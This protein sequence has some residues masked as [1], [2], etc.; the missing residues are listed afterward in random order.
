MDKKQN[1]MKVLIVY[2]VGLADDAKS[3]FREYVKQGIDLSVILPKKIIGGEGYAPKGFTYNANV[4]QQPYQIIPV[5]LRKPE[6]YGEGF[7]FFQLFFAIK[8]IKPDVIHVLDEYTS[9]YLFQV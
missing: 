3:F 9:F 1:S 8:K 7:T 6:S 5:P 4:N 2:H